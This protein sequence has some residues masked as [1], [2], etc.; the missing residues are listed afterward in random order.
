[1]IG[2]WQAGDPYLDILEPGGNVGMIKVKY[3][4]E[5]NA[6]GT[7]VRAIG[8]DDRVV[9]SA[10]PDL[11]G[12]FNTRVAWKNLDL[13]MVGAF[14]VGGTLVSTL[15]SGSG[16]LNMLTGRRG[17]VKVDYWTEENTGAKYPKPGGAQSGDNPKYGGL[18]GYFDATYLKVRTIT[19]GYN[20]ENLAWVKRNLG[21][22][23]LRLYATVQN[24]FV[25][26][27]PYHNESGMDPETN[28]YGNENVAVAGRRNQLIVGTNAPVTRNYLFGLNI[29]F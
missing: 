25:L 4:G 14:K 18:L 15:Y 6:D 26:F 11:Q 23:Q 19:L 22:Q 13:T 1:M 10:D 7:P 28:S 9:R 27:S 5:Y 29:T 17:Q 2:L 20:F 12:G 24:P 21:V 8:D 3:L 16:Y